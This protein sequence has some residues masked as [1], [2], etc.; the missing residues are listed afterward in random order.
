MFFIMY[1]LSLVIRALEWYSID[2]VSRPHGATDESCFQV[3]DALA[4]GSRRSTLLGWH[5]SNM[6]LLKF[7]QVEA[8][9][10]CLTKAWLKQCY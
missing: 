3:E 1:I 10:A 2:P 9:P 8:V 6:K 4:S 7:V 5:W